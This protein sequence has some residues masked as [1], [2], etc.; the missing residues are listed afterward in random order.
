MLVTAAMP[1]LRREISLLSLKKNATIRMI[2][3]DIDSEIMPS[4]TAQTLLPSVS[5]A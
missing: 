2:S 1:K 4:R 3:S 5:I